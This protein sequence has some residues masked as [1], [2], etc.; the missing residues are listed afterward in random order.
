MCARITQGYDT[1]EIGTLIG[2]QIDGEPEQQPLEWNG[3][4]GQPYLIVRA[5]GDGGR[6]RLDPLKW[7]LIPAGMK[8]DT[9]RAVNARSETAATLPSFRKSFQN[10]RGLFP[11]TGWYEWRKVKGQKQPYHIA[12]AEG[13]TLL[14][15]VI[16]EAARPGGRYG[17]TFA[18][19]TTS[20]RPEIAHIHDRQ[21]SIISPPN[22][23]DWLSNAETAQR[24]L[25]MQTLACR[26]G[27]TT[28]VANPVSRRVNNPANKAAD[29]AT[30]IALAC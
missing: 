16:C 8:D 5:G 20:P 27:N 3:A 19:L 4:P 7:G 12:P 9:F 15:A 1:R 30:P 10:G 29:T 28:L 13:G 26:N 6:A 24:R 11:V 14:L 23:A 18:V 25:L 22:A 2:M 21:P 17:E